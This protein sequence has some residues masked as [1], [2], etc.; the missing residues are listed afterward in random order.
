MKIRLY[1]SPVRPEGAAGELRDWTH[2]KK[3]INVAFYIYILK[4]SDGSYYTGHT[5]NLEQRIS[6]HKQGAYEGYTA[7]RLPVTLVFV[8]EFGSRIEALEAERKIKTWNRRK[9]EILI[10]SGWEGFIKLRK[11]KNKI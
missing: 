9:K 8:E 4:C 5:D 3:G 6:A 10:S 2:I 7:N 11:I 1:Y